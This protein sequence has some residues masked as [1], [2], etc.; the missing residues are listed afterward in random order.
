MRYSLAVFFFFFSFSISAQRTDVDTS[1]LK[2]WFTIDTLILEKGLDKTALIKVNELYQKASQ[3]NLSAQKLKSLIYRYSLENNITEKGYKGIIADLS[4][5]IDTEKVPAVKA[6]L[7]LLL[8]KKMIRYCNDYRWQI[9]SRKPSVNKAS[10]DIDTWSMNDFYREISSLYLRSIK[11]EALLQSIPMQEFDAVLVRGTKSYAKSSLYDLAVREALEFFKYGSS[12]VSNPVET[13]S[14]KD[15]KALSPLT[16]FIQTSFHTQDSSSY[17]WQSLSLYKKILKHHS[18]DTDKELLLYLDQERI[19]WAYT[20]AIFPNRE[21]KYEQALYQLTTQYKSYPGTAEV[22][23]QLAALYINRA[24]GYTPFGDTANRYAYV[25][26]KKIIENAMPLY[27]SNTSGVIKM[28]NQLASI[29]AV[30]MMVKTELVN[31]A[32]Q[33]FRAKLEYR[34]MDS[35]YI[36]ILKIDDE[37]MAGDHFWGKTFWQRISR[38]KQVRSLSL[39]IPRTNDHQMHGTELPIPGLAPGNYALL[40]SNDALFND[41]LSYLRY[42]PFMVSN[43]SYIKNEADFFVLH[44][45]TGKPL[46]DVKVTV[47]QQYYNNTTRKSDFKTVNKLV[48][49]KNG[50]FSFLEKN[51]GG[52]YRYHF[53]KG[54]DQLK[55]MSWEYEYYNAVSNEDILDPEEESRLRYEK[56]NRQVFFFT[57]RSIYRPGQPVYFKGI[58]LTREFGTQKSK[59]LQKDTGWA[60]LQ[61]VNGKKIDSI[62]FR[63]NEYGSFNG[64]FQLPAKALTGYFS[65]VTNS[66]KNG[67]AYFSVE[68]YKR[69]TYSVAFD[70]PKGSYRLNDSIKLTGNAKAYAGNNIDDAKVTYQITRNVRRLYPWYWKGQPRYENSR[71]ISN[72]SLITDAAGNFTISFNASADDIRKE[73]D[74]NTLFVFTVNATVTDKNGETRTASTEITIG[75]QSLQLSIENPQLIDRKEAKAIRVKTTNLSNEPEPANVAIK[76]YALQT[77]ERLIRK[78]LWEKPDQFMLK[79]YEFISLFPYDEYAEE[80]DMTTW[81]VM[82]LVEE[83]RVNTKE[84]ASLLL[85]QPLEAGQYKVEAI[86]TDKDG[87]QVKATHYMA[88]FNSSTGQMPNTVY[89]FTHNVKTKIEPGDTALYISGSAAKEFFVIKK[90]ATKNN[91][92]FIEYQ[93]R[94]KGISEQLFTAKETDRG[95]AAIAE[96]YILHNRLYT[97]QTSIEIPWSDKQLN[98]SYQTFRN[99]TEPGS[100]ETWTVQVKGS[101]NKPVAA[102]LLTTMYDASLDQFRNH[103]LNTPFLWQIN[104]FTNYFAPGRNFSISNQYENPIAIF[105]YLPEYTETP[106]RLA[107]SNNDLY[108]RNIR[109][110]IT[111]ANVSDKLKKQVEKM[112]EDVVGYNMAS[113][114][115]ARMRVE[116]S[117]DK[118]TMYSFSTGTISQL[119]GTNSLSSITNTSN[120]ALVMADTGMM[121]NISIRGNSTLNKNNIGLPQEET[122]VTI[123]KNFN[124]TAFFFPNLYADTAGNYSFS[125]TMPDALTKWK[126]MSLAHT[127]DLAFGTNSTS[128]VT[129]KT[130]MVQANAPRFIREGDKME[131]SGKVVNLSDKELSGQVT[132]EL[133]DAVTGSSVDG[134]FQNVFPVQYFTAAA[135]QSTAIKF[136]IQVPFSFNKTLSWRLIARADKYSDGEENM[137][138]VLTN[139]Q[140]VT[141]SLPIL[142]TKDTTQSFRF[143]KLLQANS[144]SLTHEGISINYTANPIWEAIRALPYLMEY[145]YECVEQTFN[146]FYANALG[147]Y[148]VN[149]DPKI[150]KVF[151]AWLKDT[152]TPKS[153]LALN[154]S[155]KQI[156]LEETPWVF[157]AQSQE[158]QQKNIALLFDLFRLNQQADQ[159]VKKL[160]DMQLS[161]GSFS[162]F[163]GGYGDRYMTNYV[164][165]GIGKLKRTGALTPDIAIQLKPVIE[166][167]IRFLDEEINKEYQ[168][169]KKAKLDTSRNLI[170]TSHIQYL[171]MRSFFRDVALPKFAEAYHFFYDRGK[172]QIQQQSI[173]NRA[174]LG[175]VYY[176]NNEIRYVNVNI[177][178]AILENTVRDEAKASLYWKDRLTYSWYQTPIEH[179]ATM[180]QFL[181]ELQQ[182]QPMS[183]GN[184]AIDEARNWLL[185][186]KQTNHWNTTVAT[187]EA[188]YALLL[189][190]TDLLH[191]DKNIRIQLGNTSF[192]SQDQPTEAGTGYFQQRIEGRLVNPEMGNIK[193]TVQTK[194]NQQIQSPSWGSIYWQYFEDMDKIKLSA[195][196]LS[197]TKQLFIERN[198]NSGKVLESVKENDVLKPGD[199]VVVRLTIKSDRE[200]EYLHLKDTRA[201]TME[202]VNVLSG[203]KWQDGL[204]YYESTKDASTNFFISQLR[205]GTYVFDYPVFITHTGVFSTGNASIQC[206]Y[207]PEFT[208][209][210]GGM[211]IR[212]EE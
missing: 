211:M 160:Q 94:K 111:Y 85:Q 35:L 163:K 21:Q 54:N 95:G 104:N 159:L 187:A 180:I 192:S 178:T 78:R 199:K 92:S 6:V 125:F 29:H 168:Y 128:I 2:E 55:F 134:W 182:G 133:I 28:K 74:N 33:P 34:N 203:Y 84:Q 200:M 68:E 3:R 179:Q 26:A 11:E 15:E 189:T 45:E 81:P 173:Y 91:T 67:I 57:D 31:T 202:P 20:H 44:R 141:E 157:A 114:K 122:P 165:T 69:P 27:D 135:G 162:W 154:E 144:P 18:N 117:Y 155:L 23:S 101:K 43:I 7:E 124:E 63:L 123:R 139:R 32:N 22:W 151:E 131:F 161:D 138:P 212:V 103:Q 47:Q 62:P 108:E 193:I 56:N 183:G 181:Q 9:Y 83:G 146:R 61:D 66:I 205:K 80:T 13:F 50:H 136:P 41:S 17:T 210:S 19:N 53:E 106:D 24:A 65:I 143:E 88:V 60:I 149:R 86:T 150:K 118:K 77:P 52:Y 188:C 206:M 82:K 99:K 38:Q 126:W 158:E 166:K 190:G 120:F 102:E 147:T 25:T 58:G 129:Q 42:L 14:L 89:Q 177:R 12:Y 172:Y 112:L 49:D 48:T 169:W 4:T 174:L 132:L 194:G 72:G 37:D 75:Y 113:G 16:A 64:K 207:A 184:S 10:K 71:E 197:V 142:I 176:R 30:Q 59:L 196:P 153:K 93:T 195:T 100:K 170:S 76:V 46:A 156:M 137:L 145:P 167:A 148:I 5:E 36:R 198:S 152:A 70:K 1:F 191:T 96:A 116:E 90:T 130:L 127:R 109:Q 39:A 105:D 40:C 110:W 98:I 107:E 175:L 209:N 140:L 208:A 119:A 171:Y 204:G 201:S 8:A 73:E 185:L 79:E 97:F 186:N 87:Q 51:K 164:L 121:T 115:A